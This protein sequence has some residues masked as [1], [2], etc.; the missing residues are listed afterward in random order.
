[1]KL[2]CDLGEGADSEAAVM[3]HIDQVNIACGL[4]AGNPKLMRETLRL[5]KAHGVSVG[6]HPGYAD[7]EGFGRQSV[8]CQPIEIVE[9]VRQQ[10]A[11]L[12]KL[13]KEEGIT[14][15]YLK[16]HGALYHDM[17]T[18]DEVRTAIF[19]AVDQC[20]A[21]LALMIQATPGI[22]S[23]RAEA[24]QAGMEL[25]PEAFADRRYDISGHLLPRHMAGA[26][27]NRSQM[28][29]QVQQLVTEGSVT[30]DTGNKLEVTADTLCVH[31]DNE[32]GV[33]CICDIRKLLSN[34]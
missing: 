29:E 21:S 5:A 1:M 14:I 8:Y 22:E 9:L 26:I 15:D 28:L 18:K 4:H 11:V 17:M 20:P 3:P 27:L 23:H 19:S 12:E 16:P 10:V 30:T 24:S 13:A 33:Q 2:N 6:A 34:G 7:R 31:G 25:W 32:E